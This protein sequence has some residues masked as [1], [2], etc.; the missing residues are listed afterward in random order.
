M[1]FDKTFMTIGSHYLILE[2]YQHLQQLFSTV[3]L[4]SDS[5]AKFNDKPEFKAL[6]IWEDHYPG[7]GPLG[8]ITTALEM[9]ETPYVFIVACDMPNISIPAI[10]QLY[11]QR[12]T[13]QVILYEQGHRLETLFAIYHVSC[14]R[15]FSRSVNENR[16]RIRDCFQ[17]LSLSTIPLSGEN[18]E[19][20]FPNLN[21]PAEY[22]LWESR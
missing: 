2:T 11:D 14:R 1:G 9:A 18:T 6:T 22:N 8:A 3:V 19:L 4:L 21:T 17:Y 20:S 10:Q 7:T 15:V 16:L 13:H 12:G 5:T